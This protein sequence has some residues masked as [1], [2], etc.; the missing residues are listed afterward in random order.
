MKKFLIC[1]LAFTLVLSLAA[2]T[3]QNEEEP[4]T[5]QGG[6]AVN[7]VE[8][9]TTEE[10]EETSTP[11]D[12]VVATESDATE[13]EEPTTEYPDYVYNVEED[14][15]ADKVENFDMVS[16][17]GTL[18]AFPCDYA[19]LKE[20]FVNFYMPDE[21]NTSDTIVFTDENR[22]EL[23]SAVS[24]GVT[25]YYT[26]KTGE[27][28]VKFFM[29][30]TDG[31]SCALKDMTC[32][33]F[34]VQGGNIEGKKSVTIALPKGIHIGSTSDEILEAYGLNYNSR[35]SYTDEGCKSFCYYYEPDNT[36]NVYQFTGIDG[37]LFSVKVMYND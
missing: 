21:F 3:K 32:K 12:T 26:P 20:N 27:G 4:V 8:T 37:G 11:T 24:S 29:V 14:E 31:T 33:S 30:P 36:N 1:T 15:F 23:E 5:E 13:K 7:D 22:A 2:C 18:I 34:S 17:D 9:K 35:K 25:L 19:H 6:Y 16:I 10:E 28:V